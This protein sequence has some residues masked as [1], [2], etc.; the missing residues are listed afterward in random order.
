MAIEAGTPMKGEFRDKVIIVTGGGSGIGEAAAMRLAGEAARVVIAAMNAEQGAAVV[1]RIESLGQ[2]AKFVATD[3]SREAEVQAMIKTA[4]AEYAKHGIRVNAGVSRGRRH[5][6]HARY[7]YRLEQGRTGSDGSNS[8]GQRGR[9]DGV[10]AL[11]GPLF[12]YHRSGVRH[13]RRHDGTDVHR[14]VTV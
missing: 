2:S 12:L 8:E 3:V 13:R 11:V 7:G 5:A 4:A 14:G 9:R 6:G 10:L 1:R